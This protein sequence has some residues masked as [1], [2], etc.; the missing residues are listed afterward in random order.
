MVSHTVM[1]SGIVIPFIKTQ[2]LGT[3]NCRLGALDNN[4]F[5]S[6]VQKLG[7]MDVG[8]CHNHAQWTAAL[9]HKNAPL[10]SRFASVCGIATN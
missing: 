9:F 5:Q 7:I 4:S 10:G 1:T 8:S 2:A 3:F 6:R